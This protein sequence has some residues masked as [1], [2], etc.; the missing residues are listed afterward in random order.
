MQPPENATYACVAALI[1]ELARAGVKHF[2]LC[3]GSRSTPLAVSAA[4]HPALRV[5]TLVDERSAG[6]FALGIAKTARVPTALLS[7]S[8]TA[9]ANFLPAV[10][11]ARHGRVPLIV[12][13]ADRPRTLRDCAAPQTIDQVRLYGAHAKWFVD[14][15][16][17]EGTD[18]TLRYFRTIACQAVAATL[19][20]PAGPVH[21]NVPLA[22]PLVPVDA[23]EELVPSSERAAPAWQ[24]RAAGRPY[25][26]TSR[27]PRA[28]DP[29]I[30]ERLAS[31]LSGVSRG[32]IVC[33]PHDDPLLPGAVCRLASL[34]GYPILA[35]PLSLVR[36]GSHDRSLVIDCYD[37]LLRIDDL[38]APLAPDVIVRLGGVPASKPLMGYLQRHGEAHQVV[39]DG[40]VDWRDPTRL[41]SDTFHADPRLW[42][43]ALA[44]LVP[45]AAGDGRAPRP[46]RMS[47]WASHWV[48]VNA[49]AREAIQERLDALDELFEGRVF[50]ELP[51]LLP[52]G[53]I[54]YVGNSMPVR[55]LDT[56]F[57]GTT[58]TVRVLGNRG[59]SGIDGLVSS[60]LGAA[61]TG[62]GPVVL[63]LGDLAFYHDLNGLLAAKLHR[64]HATIVLLNNDGGGIFSFLPQA[65]YPDHFEMLFGTPTG[66]DFA[67][68]AALYGAAFRRAET[69]PAFREGVREGLASDQ[70]AV[71][72]IRT[73]R[74]RNVA[75][76]REV[77]A[78][79]EAALRAQAW[80]RA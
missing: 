12:L 32:V 63:V 31:D 68:A 71:V 46:G 1:D 19:D 48:H 5:W 2:C 18:D 44:R 14:L 35:D 7:T 45:Q 28:P 36:C 16:R 29:A 57:P 72:E 22:E 23:P 39:V 9:A 55:D 56:F 4:R 76:H 66:L 17:P 78:A 6:F 77:W 67:T 52:D 64:L 60:A 25:T 73:R 43:E 41:A 38:A 50:A 61:A 47:S 53:S 70:V 37:A 58:R 34:L 30:V 75:L 62:S 15:A 80:G 65:A 11:E 33:G 10:V 13:T 27:S 3:P 42:C 51:T 54:L 24:G 74:D 8:G 79:V 69:W 20:D 49:V 26:V 59:A 40:S 21:L